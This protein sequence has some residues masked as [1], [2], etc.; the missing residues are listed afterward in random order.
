MKSE[1]LEKLASLKR[2]HPALQSNTFLHFI[3]SLWVSFAPI[4]S[5]TAMGMRI[6]IQPATINAEPYP[7]TTKLE[8]TEEK[9]GCRISLS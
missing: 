9:S 1:L 2:E 5:G 3:L 7:V 4:G 8:K 6:R